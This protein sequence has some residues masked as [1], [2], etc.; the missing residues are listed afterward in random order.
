MPNVSIS[1]EEQL[2]D[3]RSREKS[4]TLRVV[5]HG[6]D[7]IQINSVTP[8]IPDNVELIEVRDTSLIGIRTRHTDLCAELETMLEAQIILQ[9]AEV[10]ARIA[11]TWNDLWKDMTK[12][13]PWPFSDQLKSLARRASQKMGALSFTVGSVADAERGKALFLQKEGI[14]ETVLKLYDGK[15]EQLKTVEG[16]LTDDSESNG[17][18]LVAPDSF[19]AMGYTLRFPRNRMSP[20][21]YSVAIDVGY[22]YVTS[23]QRLLGSTSGTVVITPNPV[24]LSV[25]SAVAGVLGWIVHASYPLIA[26]VAGAQPIVYN[27]RSGGEIAS[28][29][30]LAF[31]LFNIYENLDFAKKVKL[32]VSWRSAVAIGVCCG[33][34]SERIIEAL[35]A[36]VGGK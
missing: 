3:E 14:D 1:L 18:A 7:A 22:S 36:I 26:G 2:V 34:F 23:K 27:A 5:N 10:R 32:G 29:A 6:P 21:Q 11:Q 31:V 28:S 15:L 9:S 30:I 35:S 16:K 13:I 8:R 20:K 19:F 4:Y 33:L 25:T 24:L 17:L 12:R